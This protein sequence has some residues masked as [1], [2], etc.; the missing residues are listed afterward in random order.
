MDFGPTGEKGENGR[1]TG[2]LAQAFSHFRPFVP[3]FPGGA[4]TYFSAIFFPFRA[5]ATPARNASRE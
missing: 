5:V 1:K 2:K 3:L 4:T